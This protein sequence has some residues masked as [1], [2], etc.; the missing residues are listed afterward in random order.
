[1]VL[2]RKRG[3]RVQMDRAPV[4]TLR[5]DPGRACSKTRS[6]NAVGQKHAKFGGDAWTG[7]V[8]EAAWPDDAFQECPRR[9]QA[10]RTRCR[11]GVSTRPSRTPSHPSVTTEIEAGCR[12]DQRR[13]GVIVQTARRLQFDFHF[14]R[15]GNR[16]IG[17]VERAECESR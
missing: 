1:M 4:P 11:E 15:I 17:P 10:R 7:L 12:R 9:R 5:Y 14:S 2:T 16:R 6:P 3:C 13:A 8:L